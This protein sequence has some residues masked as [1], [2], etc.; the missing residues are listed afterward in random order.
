MSHGPANLHDTVDPHE[1]LSRDEA[2]AAHV[3][4]T[5]YWPMLWVFVALLGFTGLTVWSSNIHGFWI[6]N[7]EIVLG[8]TEHILIAM[9]IAIVKALLVAAYF[10]HLKYDQPMNT[11][12]VGAT[13]FAVILFIGL[14]VGDMASRD[15]FDPLQHKKVIEGG[16]AHMSKDP[17]T[18]ELVYT[19]GPGQVQTAIQN[20]HAAAT[21]PGAEAHGQAAPSG[22][23]PE[24]A[25]K[26]EAK[27][28]GH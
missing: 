26:D 23:E 16:S 25:K 7:T 8:A 4:V 6:G 9:S 3:H 24:P 27:P 14:T 15:V 1:T 13:M 17:T 22:H 5:P 20:A 18:G 10:M 21:N 2:H 12:V 11:V 28:A 19:V